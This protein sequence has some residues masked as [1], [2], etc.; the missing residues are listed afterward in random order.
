MSLLAL[1]QPDLFNP[2]NV[3]IGFDLDSMDQA[4]SDPASHREEV[5]TNQCYLE[6]CGYW[7]LPTFAINGEPFFGQGRSDTLRWRLEKDGLQRKS[8]SYPRLVTVLPL[9]SQR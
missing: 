1:R 3:R 2:E 6:A 4:I 5:A 7:G 9:C 8:Q